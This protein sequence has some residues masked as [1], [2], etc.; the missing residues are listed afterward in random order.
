MQTNL[1]LVISN[2][3]ISDFDT[4][5]LAAMFIS[6]NAMMTFPINPSL[7]DNVI[8]HTIH[9]LCVE[10]RSAVCNFFC[11]AAS[12]IVLAELGSLMFEVTHLLQATL[13]IGQ[14]TT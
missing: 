12:S 7:R 9:E 14:C 10:A 1:L 6:L 2:R 8:T 3:M 5:I 13:R 11:N 4:D